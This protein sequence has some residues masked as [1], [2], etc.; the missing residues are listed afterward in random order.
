MEWIS[1]GTLVGVHVSA[2][3]FNIT[4]VIIADLLG[5]LWVL[6]YKR[7]LNRRTMQRLHYLI[8]AGLA[9]SIISGAL[10]FST[11]DEYL[12]TVPAFY[13]KVG[14]VL[15][16]VVNSFFIGRHLKVATERSFRSLLGSEKLPI[17]ISAAVSVASWI[18]VVVAAQ[19]L[20]L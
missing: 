13:T 19:F 7:T 18:G 5:L 1:Y 6:G 14:F 20:G 12:L 16:L 8:S 4:L 10:L 17:F 3:L 15:A 2:F 9:V 11:A